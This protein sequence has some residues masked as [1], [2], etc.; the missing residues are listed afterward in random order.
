[1]TEYL[2]LETDSP[3]M[4]L[5]A[6]VRPERWLPPA[7]AAPAAQDLDLLHHLVSP[8]CE[9]RRLLRHLQPAPLWGIDLP[10][11]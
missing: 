3:Y 7:T 6:Q 4:L 2:T 9:E 1:M 8:V 5:V 10:L 11:Q